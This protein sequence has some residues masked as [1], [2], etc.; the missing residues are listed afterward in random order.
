ME[1]Y[2]VAP[3]VEKKMLELAGRYGLSLAALFGSVAERRN[4][5]GSDVDVAYM[6]GARLSLKDELELARELALLF[7]APR[8]D[9]VYLPGASPLFMYMILQNGVVLFEKDPMLFPSLYTYAVSR[10]HDNMPLYQMR[11]DYLCRQYHVR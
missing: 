1:K 11:F 3:E 10:F 6:S 8:A 4:R 2:R 7:K 9:L 5:K